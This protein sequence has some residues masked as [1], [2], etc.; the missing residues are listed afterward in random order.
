VS[1]TTKGSSNSYQFAAL[2]HPSDAPHY[3]A[4]DAQGNPANQDNFGPGTYADAD[5]ARANNAVA[6]PGESPGQIAELALNSDQKFLDLERPTTDP[7]VAP[8]IKELEKKFGVELKP[9]DSVTLKDW[10]NEVHDQIQQG[11]IPESTL[12][13]IQEV[14]KSQGFDGYKYTNDVNPDSPSNK[15]LMFDENH[16]I[17]QEMTANADV[18]PSMTG[19]ELQSAVERS[20]SS[21]ASKWASPESDHEIRTLQDTLSPN[22]KPEYMDPIVKESFDADRAQLEEMVKKDPSLQSELD[23]LDEQFK[24]AKKDQSI[25]KSFADC[26]MRSIS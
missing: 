9:S 26:V 25:L 2:E 11:S 15:V 21:D 24:D 16:P 4:R 12:K 5:A 8:M 22:Q 13:D 10:L 19:A 18:T 7:E 3:A 14:A 1:G 20:Q 23:E 6:S 17:N